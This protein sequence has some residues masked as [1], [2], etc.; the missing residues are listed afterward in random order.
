MEIFYYPFS[1]KFKII[2]YF[3]QIN[4]I[5]DKTNNPKTKIQ[6]KFLWILFF[7]YLDKVKSSWWYISLLF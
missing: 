1:S 6:N 2:P 7:N 4:K 5:D 3:L